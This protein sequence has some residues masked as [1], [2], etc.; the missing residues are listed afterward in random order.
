MYLCIF[1]KLIATSH[2]TKA[3]DCGVITIRKMT[4]PTETEVRQRNTGETR[5]LLLKP[6][7]KNTSKV[8]WSATHEVMPIFCFDIN[9]RYRKQ[10]WK[11]FFL[12]RW[13][14]SLEWL[15]FFKT[16]KKQTNKQT[17]KVFSPK[18]FQNKQTNKQ[19]NKDERFF[20]QRWLVSLEWLGFFN[21]TTVGSASVYRRQGT[22]YHRR[23]SFMELYLI[24]IELTSQGAWIS[25]SCWNSKVCVRTSGDLNLQSLLAP[26]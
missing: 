2:A 9:T 7:L 13:L 20:L 25:S 16:N 26:T 14:V 19:T 15:G 4:S 12:Q 17:W 5:N 6:H 22:L 21:G 11:V 8:V 18:I 3:Y 23:F 10:T 24:R 1:E